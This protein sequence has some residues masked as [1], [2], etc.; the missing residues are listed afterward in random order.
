MGALRTPIIAS[1]SHTPPS[2]A[3]KTPAGASLF[4]IGD[5][6]EPYAT[7]KPTRLQRSHLMNDF[8]SIRDAVSRVAPRYTIA[9]VA[10]F[11]LYASDQAR[12]GVLARRRRA[13]PP[14]HRRGPRLHGRR[15]LPLGPHRRR[16]RP[17]GN[18]GPC[19]VRE[20]R[21]DDCLHARHPCSSRS[22]S[23][24]QAARPLVPI[25]AAF[26]QFSQKKAARHA[27]S[28]SWNPTHTRI[29]A[30]ERTTSI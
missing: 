1:L 4:A 21:R 26:P 19:G 5:I 3:R 9:K 22:P 12:T 13:V 14:L 27:L 30:R 28:L 15:G 17:C 24:A 18:R 23:R 20:P 25:C 2:R 29:A 8:G 10:V 6:L 11:S 7:I 16:L